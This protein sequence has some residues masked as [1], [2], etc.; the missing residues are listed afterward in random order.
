MRKFLLFMTL[1]LWCC[2]TDS[3]NSVAGGPGSETTNG[4]VAMVDGAKASY[5]A[6]SLRRVDYKAAKGEVE[7]VMVNPDFYAD[8]LG[9]IDME[10]R[11]KSLDKGSYRLTIIHGGSSF[12]K[13]YTVEQM[14]KEFNIEDGKDVKSIALPHASSITGSIDMPEGSDFVWVGVRGLD[15]LIKT[16][17]EGNF[18]LPFL[19]AEDS[20]KLYF[21]DEKYK[22][23]YDSTSVELEPLINKELNLATPKPAKVEGIVAMANGKPASFASVAL[24]PA[25]AIAELDSQEASLIKA[26]TYANEDGVFNVKEPEGEGLYR[27]TV[28]QDGY[29]YSV[30]VK[31]GEIDDLDTVQLMA[32]ASMSGKVSLKSGS[33]YSWAGV[34]GLD[35]LVKTDKLGNYSFPTLPANDSLNVYFVSENDSI[36]YVDRDFSLKSYDV[37][38]LYPS[39][40]IGDFEDCEDDMSCGGWYVNAGPTGSSI[41][42]TV[43]SKAVAY[44]SVRKSNVFHATYSLSG[45]GSGVWVLLGKFISE[46]DGWN[47][48]LLDSVEVYAKGDGNIRIY[49]ENWEY[50]KEQAGQV[51]KAASDLRALSSSWKRFVFKPSDLCVD[52]ADDGSANCKKT[53][54]SVKASIK[55][56]SILPYSGKEF[57]I[58]DIRLHGTLF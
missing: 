32:T 57:Y 6:V 53:W 26:D 44:D 15:V 7:N 31:S 47:L 55:Q 37:E 50:D 42:P 18:A 25:S 16:D 43:V 17:S 21:V 27:L 28:A 2:S 19:P 23:F 49:L 35:V 13:E 39:M 46:D 40:L 34:Y 22:K 45:E 5:A 4:I 20:L 48:S 33:A 30:V 54:E 41:S 38:F 51:V 24:R 1:A 14:A 10:Q 52:Y 56:F 3:G 12:S 58:D 36:P 8:S 9:F 11:I 29:V